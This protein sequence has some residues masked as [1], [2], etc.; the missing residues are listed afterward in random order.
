MTDELELERTAALLNQVFEHSD[1]LTTNSLRW[2]Y[3]ENPAG[4]AAVGRVE[5]KE[6][7]WGT[8]P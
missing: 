3:D 6:S 2:Y 1:P 7:A 8:T 5:E 4:S